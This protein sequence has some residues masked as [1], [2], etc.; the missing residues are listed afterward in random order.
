MSVRG[1]RRTLIGA[2]QVP[3]VQQDGRPFAS[4]AAAAGA[5]GAIET[6]PAGAL[7]GDG[8]VA[9]PLAVNV[10]GTTVIINVLNQLEVT[11]SSGAHAVTHQNGG[12]D[13]MNVGGLSGLLA[14]GQTPLAHNTSHQ[15]GGS[16][17]I[18]LD[19]LAAPDDNADLNASITKHGLLKK[20][21]DVALEFFNGKGNYVALPITCLKKTA[22]QTINGGAGVFVDITELTF[23]VVNGTVYAFKFYIVFRS[24][25]TTTGYK[26]S[27]NCPAGTLDFFVTHQTVANS[28]TVGVATWL[29]RH[30]FTR[31]DMTALITSIAANEDLVVMIEGRYICTADGTFAPRFANELVA[32]TDLVVQIGSWGTV[33]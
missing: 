10:D 2:V 7:L 18:K 12:A 32:N 1:K 11:G 14:D 9:D 23:P 26:V 24:A 31:D 29:Q 28:S 30:S 21:S 22:T 4:A 27:V 5:A 15:T 16:D 8:S 3:V 20:L 6:D 33:F 13:E 17:A 19:D 25:A